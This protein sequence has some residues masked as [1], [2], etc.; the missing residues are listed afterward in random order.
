[1]NTVTLELPVD[2]MSPGETPEAF[3]DEAR[4][5]LAL[6]LFEM[7]RLSSGKAARMCGR[8]RVEFLLAAGR[9]GVAVVGMEGEELANEL[10]WDD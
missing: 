4:F 5:I 7:G 10:R 3:A 6:K 2:A 1:M 9:E 8:S